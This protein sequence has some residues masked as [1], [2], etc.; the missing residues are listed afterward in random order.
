MDPHFNET[1]IGE[2]KYQDLDG[3]IYEEKL[4]IKTDMSSQL[5]WSNI[6][7]SKDTDEVTAIKQASQNIVKA[8]K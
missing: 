3:I 8:F 7:N 4:N 6:R 1:V 2:I 5:R